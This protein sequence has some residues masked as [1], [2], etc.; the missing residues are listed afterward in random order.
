MG[1]IKATFRCDNCGRER[2]VRFPTK[3]GRNR[4][5]GWFVTIFAHLV[6]YACSKQCVMEW[7]SSHSVGRLP[8]DSPSEQEEEDNTT[9]PFIRA[10]MERGIPVQRLKL[11]DLFGGDK[12]LYL[13]LAKELKVPR[14]IVVEFFEHVTK[15]VCPKCKAQSEERCVLTSGDDIRTCPEHGPE[16][17]SVVHSERVEAARVTW[18]GKLQ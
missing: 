8:V 14:E 18:K 3:D 15:T 13:E 9:P 1:I 10:L 12:D 6:V 2:N 7:D 4:P 5:R 16:L 11:S 17:N